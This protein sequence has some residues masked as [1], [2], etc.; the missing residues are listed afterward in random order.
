MSGFEV[1][2]NFAEGTNIICNAVPDAKVYSL[3]L[4]YESMMKNPKEFPIGINGEDRVGSVGRFSFTQ[5]RGDS[6][7]F[8]Y[9]K[10]PCD[11]YYIDGEHTELAVTIEVKAILKTHP[12]LI[13]LHDTDMPEVMVGL[14]AGVEQSE[15]SEHYELFRIT[16]TRISYLLRR[17]TQQIET[18]S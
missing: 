12:K 11:A 1:G 16:E 4:D 2:T 5:L 10:Y 6:M 13:I 8:D 9:M 15:E 17:E 14:L 3:D 18:T 7:T